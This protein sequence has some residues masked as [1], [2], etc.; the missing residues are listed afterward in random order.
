MV[1]E[2]IL[3]SENPFKKVNNSNVKKEEPPKVIREPID[4]QQK[5]LDNIFTSSPT[6]NTE[7]AVNKTVEVEN[8]EPKTEVNVPVNPTPSPLTS[9]SVQQ[10]QQTIVTPIQNGQ[11][12]VVQS[13]SFLESPK[14]DNLSN[15]NVVTVKRKSNLDEFIKEIYER[16]CSVMGD[17]LKFVI[18]IYGKKGS[19]K[20][21]LAS[22]FPGNT[23]ILSF[24]SK[25]FTGNRVIKEGRTI[26]VNMIE[27][28][29]TSSDESKL[30][31]ASNVYTDVLTLLSLASQYDIDWIVFDSFETLSQ[32]CEM[33]MRKE[34]G[35][36]PY[37]GIRNLNLWKKR[38]DYI[39]YLYKKAMGAAK[40]GVIFTSHFTIEQVITDGGEFAKEVPAWSQNIMRETDVI[41]KTDC[42]YV[43]NRP[44]FRI[45][46]ESS[47][48]PEIFPMVTVDIT[49]DV[50]FDEVS[51]EYKVK[52][53][54]PFK[55]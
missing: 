55:L 32:I 52:L 35:L 38:N 43:N 26:A 6:N 40:K 41:I 13:R 7:I 14:Q 50:I 28:Y 31:S 36:R 5:T 49:A 54:L 29:D 2:N 3:G 44:H 9:V 27:K 39:Y 19:G 37:E 45:T 33:K 16:G 34:E 53:N 25:S 23:L 10:T 46:V 21:T 11:S 30:E 8:N 15:Q 12:Q 17:P 22:A 20:T 4:T 47:K 1:F 24:D 18:F 48:I 51:K 42:S